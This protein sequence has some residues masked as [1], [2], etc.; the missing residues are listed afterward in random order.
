MNPYSNNLE[1]E[2]EEFLDL[3]WS[4]NNTE[5]EGRS[6]EGA[7]QKCLIRRC[8]SSMDDDENI[9]DGIINRLK[10]FQ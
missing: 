4:D 8:T 1:E 7:K 6:S 2:F 3:K 9:R 5:G 10:L